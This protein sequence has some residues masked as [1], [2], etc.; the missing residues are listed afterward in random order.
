VRTSR[1]AVVCCCVVLIFVVAGF[2]Q[3][4]AN[5]R[6][7]DVLKSSVDPTLS[8][9]EAQ[10]SETSKGSLPERAPAATT[11]LEWFTFDSGGSCDDE[12]WTT[13][14]M[15]DQGLFFHI[16]DFSGLG[17]G[18]K[19]MLVPLAGSK[20]LW[21]GARATDTQRDIE[22]YA[23]LPGYGNSWRQE[24]RSNGP[25]TVSGDVSIQFQISYDT[26]PSYDAITVQYSDE[27][28]APGTDPVWSTLLTYSGTGSDM[29]NATIPAANLPLG[30]VSFRFIFTSD[31]AW[32][33]QDGYQNSD[34]AAIIDELVVSDA[35]GL[36]STEDFESE[37]PGDVQTVDGQWTAYSF[38]F[39]THAALHSGPTVLQQGL[40]NNTSCL[41][42]FFGGG[43]DYTCGGFP[44]Q[45]V[46]PY[47]VDSARGEHFYN[48]IWSP[49]ITV[50]EDRSDLYLEWD[51]YSDLALSSGVFYEWRARFNNGSGWTQWVS[52]NFLWYQAA[53]DWSS[54][55]IRLD[56][57]SPVPIGLNTQVQVALGARDVCYLGIYSCLCHSNGPLF[58]NIRVYLGGT[59]PVAVQHFEARER[60]AG[61]ELSWAVDADDAIRGYRVLR[62]TEGSNDETVVHPQSLL[63]A[64]QTQFTDSSTDP[65]KS[66]G[67]SLVVVSQT[68]A[69]TRS[70]TIG[71]M[72]RQSILGLEQNSP[73]PFNP[74]TSIRFTLDRT[75]MVSLKIYDASGKLVKSLVDRS[76]IPGSYV[77]EWDGRDDHGNA[78]SSG[79]YFYRL[80]AGQRSIS[81]KAILLK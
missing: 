51:V 40:V 39:G 72:T 33:D 20:S 65:G 47:K 60:D 41:W 1:I 37:S 48:E 25:F 21:C 81:K 45:E 46:V 44:S 64:S 32:S 29:A 24:F 62:S 17:G 67:Y 31:G 9:V 13:Q 18:D 49:V 70:R 22:Y 75:E 53:A 19:G 12:G 28:H 2:T 34:G 52:D 10:L 35:S 55:Q 58:D 71:V 42:G 66:Y 57:W 54:T 43:A 8:P 15:T 63:P 59:V 11:I 30:L 7:P 78:V 5:G 56:N 73:N 16:D 38:A 61:V 27:T 69:E 50:T 4:D 26:E 36:V 76:M 68:G 77:E 14:D 3:D 6:S 74:V 79:L 23:T 80:V